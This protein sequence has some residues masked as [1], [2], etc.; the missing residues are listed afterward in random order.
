MSRSKPSSPTTSSAEA[1]APAPFR[2]ALAAA[3]AAAP[4]GIVVSD[5]NRA[6]CPIV[7]ANPAFHRI[8]GYGPA[9]VIG[10][11]C[12]FLQ[13][14]ATD[15]ASVHAIRR[16]MAERRPAD[17]EIVNYR[18][19][20][21]RFVNELH[22][23]PVFGAN[24]ELEYFF[25]IQHDVTARVRL[26]Q[27]TQRARRAAERASAEKSDFLAFMSHEIRTPMNGVMGTVSLLLDTTLD[28]EQRAYAETARRCG[29]TLLHTVNEMLD[30]SRIEAG[31]LALE[32]IPFDLARPVTEVLDLLGPAAAEKG[33]RLS[34]SI[35]PLLPA[36]LVGDPQRLRQVLLNLADNAVKFTPSGG[37]G[38]RVER[39]DAEGRVRFV[40]ADTGIGIPPEVQRRLFRRFAQGAADTARRFGGSG[41]GLMICRQLVGL[42]G[43][44]I[45]L[46]STPGKGSVFAFEI[47]LPAVAESGRP[48][49]TLLPR[50]AAATR[51]A[52]TAARG[53]ILLA[54]DGE[55]NQL[56]AAAI[57]RK[58]GYAVDLARDGEEALGM[59]RTAAYDLVLM[60]VR[61]PRMDGFAATA[62]IRALPGAAGRVPIIAM[63]ASAMA[64]DRERCIGAGMD[65]HLAKPT[66]RATL[67]GAVEEALD[68]RPRR[69][70]A[71]GPADEPHTAP[72]LLDLAT[73]DELRSAVGPGRLPRL[74]GVFAEETRARL[75]RL[76]ATA[77]LGAIEE[78]AH[79]LKSAAGT[80]GAAALRQAAEALETACVAKDSAAALALRDTLPPL[81]ERSLAAY[82]LRMSGGI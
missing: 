76:A 35:D 9:E 3:V 2:D 14:P 33:I 19:D 8:T 69:P 37:V 65:G 59:A 66:D 62:A 10:R 61:M 4:T 52:A 57:L 49:S 74:I 20:G 42:M 30:L 53:R 15:P 77:D 32:A 12:R 43:G 40:V 81:V 21:T 73:L 27:A 28:A 38:L 6:D 82:P 46:T 70:R 16:A 5:P 24:G 58:A 13:G 18:R 7:Y 11:N 29:E 56:V 48:P 39:A 50:P 31:R 23:S 67:L 55:A 80:F 68:A 64:G 60:D 26:A 63:T 41:L 17:V 54:E 51:G 45:T 36:R 25:G 72:A 47:A 75:A 34:A 78:E 22:I 44:R 1:S 71:V 79:G